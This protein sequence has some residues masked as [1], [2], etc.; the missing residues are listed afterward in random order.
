[1]LRGVRAGLAASDWEPALDTGKL[2]FEVDGFFV[3]ELVDGKE[4]LLMVVCK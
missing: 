4:M 1:L 3:I 2:F